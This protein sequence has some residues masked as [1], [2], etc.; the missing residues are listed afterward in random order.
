MPEMSGRDLKEKINQIRSGI[1]CLFMSGYSKDIMSHNGV[2]D[3]GIHFLQK[4]FTAEALSV[5]V[6]EALA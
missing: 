5:K 2:L 3:E 4:P 1:K 6:R